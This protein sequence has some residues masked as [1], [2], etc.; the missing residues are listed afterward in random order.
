[1]S[2]LRAHGCRDVVLIGPVKRPGL[3]DLRPDA[4]GAR[5][6]ARSGRAFFAGDDGLWAAVVRV[7]GEEGFAVPG[8]HEFLAGGTGRRGTLGRHQPDE[9]A[10]A[11]IARG[12]SVLA[13]L[14]RVDVGQA[15]VVQQGAVLAVEAIE[16][17]DRMLRRA[18]EVALPGPGGVL[19]KGCKPGQERRADMPALGPE[20]VAASVASG[21]RG[22]AFEA[23]G[24]LL[25]DEGDVVARADAAGLFVIGFD[26]DQTEG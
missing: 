16:G 24:T 18:G 14:G 17:T 8:A 22:I 19:I 23:G 10:R 20:T 1:M 11:D 25:I 15:C 3:R 13:A 4:E 5:L 26:P 6:L 2:L 9:Q 21:L 12:R 7:L